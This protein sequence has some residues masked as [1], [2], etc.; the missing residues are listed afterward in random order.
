MNLEVY[1]FALEI[2]LIGLCRAKYLRIDS[3]FGANVKNEN[4]SDEYK[5]ILKF[6]DWK[7]TRNQ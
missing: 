4:L 2:V 6:L 7:K 5:E 1:L 3:V